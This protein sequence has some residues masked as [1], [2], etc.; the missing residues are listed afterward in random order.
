VNDMYGFP[1]NHLVCIV[2]LPLFKQIAQAVYSRYVGTPC[3][4]KVYLVPRLLARQCY[5]MTVR[6]FVVNDPRLC[7]ISAFTTYHGLQ[8]L[9]PP[10]TN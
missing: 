5:R 7:S 9:K 4:Y 2:S 10:A 3:V 6:V 8:N 1:I